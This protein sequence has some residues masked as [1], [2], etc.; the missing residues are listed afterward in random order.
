[1]G[2]DW[3]GKTLARRSPANRLSIGVARGGQ[4]CGGKRAPM[5][6]MACVGRKKKEKKKKEKEK[7]KKGRIRKE[8]EK[9]EI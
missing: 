4:N 7:K 2:G 8:R 1:M 3:G 6:A 5:V 9:T